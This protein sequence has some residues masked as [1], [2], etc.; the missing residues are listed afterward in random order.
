VVAVTVA[1][2]V[3]IVP[4]GTA[5][6]KKNKIIATVNGKKLKAKGRHAPASYNDNGTTIL[7]SKG[8]RLIRTLGVGCAINP[9]RETTF[10][11]TPPPEVCSANYTETRVKGTNVTI[12]GWLAVTGANVTFDTFDGSRLTGRFSVVLD[13][14]DPIGAPPVTIEGTFDVG[15]LE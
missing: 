11:L 5:F 9:L 6:A 2:L 7:A 14:V 13:A 8:R 4:A 12:S 15:P 1:A 10:P 3:A